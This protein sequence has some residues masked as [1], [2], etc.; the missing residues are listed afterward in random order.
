MKV[1]EDICGCGKVMEDSRTVHGRGKCALVS[2]AAIV[3]ILVAIW[4]SGGKAKESVV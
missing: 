2:V 1:T 3:R 4:R